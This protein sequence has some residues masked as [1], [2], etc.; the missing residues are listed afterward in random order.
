MKIKS[1]L[2]GVGL[3]CGVEF[4]DRRVGLGEIGDKLEFFGNG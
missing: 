1:N 3:D 4:G 2:V